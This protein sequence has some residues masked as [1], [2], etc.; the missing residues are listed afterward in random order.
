MEDEE[1]TQKPVE[2]DDYGLEPDFDILEEEDRE[3]GY[4]C[5]TAV[6]RTTA[7]TRVYRT[8]M[9]KSVANSKLRSPK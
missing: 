9:K 6:L 8:K 4:Y 5:R 2:V 3:V 1:A 7:L